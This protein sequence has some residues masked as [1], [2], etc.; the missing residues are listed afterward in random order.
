M[1]VS[2]CAPHIELNAS[3]CSSCNKNVGY[4]SITSRALSGCFDSAAQL[5]LE[6]EAPLTAGEADNL[7]F[8]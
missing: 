5:G 3:T 8:H 4:V 6:E 2:E 1:D 7:E